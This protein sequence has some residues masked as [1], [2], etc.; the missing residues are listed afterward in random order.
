MMKSLIAAAAV[1][2]GIFTQACTA[3]AKPVYGNIGYDGAI[4]YTDVSGKT[5]A[6]TSSSTERSSNMM[7]TQRLLS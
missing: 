3:D 2:A 6:E 7:T 5:K 1:A 4:I